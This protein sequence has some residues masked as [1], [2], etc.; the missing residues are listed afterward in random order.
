MTSTRCTVDELT[1]S[2][3]ASE[4]TPV[5]ALRAVRTPM[6]WSTIGV[7]AVIDCRDTLRQALSD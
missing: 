3:A 4:P 2:S 1:D 5:N 7:D 6:A